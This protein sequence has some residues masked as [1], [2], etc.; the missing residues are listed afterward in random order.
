MS[1]SFLDQKLGIR[2][3]GIEVFFYDIVSIQESFLHSESVAF[4]ARILFDM[5]R[6]HIQGFLLA[7]RLKALSCIRVLKSDRYGDM[8]VRVNDPWHDKLSAKIRDLALILRKTC[9]VSHID[10]FAVLYRE[11]SRLRS[12]LVGCKNVRIFE[13][14][15]SFHALFLSL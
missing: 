14:P 12:I 11:S 4:L 1:L 2:T 9:L 10:E 15:I 6:H 7:I 5:L 13:D 3:Y 8:H